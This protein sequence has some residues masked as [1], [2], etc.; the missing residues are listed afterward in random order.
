MIKESE[1]Y[2]AIVVQVTNLDK[3]TFITYK[4]SLIFDYGFWNFGYGY[5]CLG[6]SVFGFGFRLWKIRLFLQEFVA[7]E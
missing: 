4:Q 1:N 7:I 5:K 3:V 2:N 6:Y